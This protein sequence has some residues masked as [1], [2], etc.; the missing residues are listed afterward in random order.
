MSPFVNLLVDVDRRWDAVDDARIELRIIGASALLMQSDYNR[1]TKD[2]DVLETDEL[3]AKTKARLLAL[4]GAGTELARRHRLYVEMVPQGLPLLPAQPDWHARPEINRQLA[5]FVVCTLD[6][7]DVV[8]SKLLRFSAND[9]SD[10]EAMVGRELVTHSRLLARFRSA[11]GWLAESARG[12]LAAA[13]VANFNRVERDMFV[14]RESAIELPDWLD[15][16]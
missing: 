9:I 16:A 2:S 4:A 5:H 6:I 1:A 10:I 13:C 7:H 11:I 8:L 14:V 15:H 3:D 12:H